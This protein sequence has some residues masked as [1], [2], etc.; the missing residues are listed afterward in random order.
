MYISLGEDAAQE[1]TMPLVQQQLIS[2]LFETKQFQHTPATL[3]FPALM[4]DV[5]SGAA[6]A[7]T[8]SL[9]CWRLRVFRYGTTTF[10]PTG[11]L[12]ESFVL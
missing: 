10:D 12:I 1:A 5:Q 4:S 8:A 9:F 7:V 2:L 11:L 6:A 3:W